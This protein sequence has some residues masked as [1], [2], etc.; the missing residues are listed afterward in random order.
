MP[1]LA[2]WYWLNYDKFPKKQVISGRWVKFHYLK[3]FVDS[4]LTASKRYAHD[5]HLSKQWTVQMVQTI[6]TTV[7][8]IKISVIWNHTLSRCSNECFTTR[9]L[10]NIPGG[11]I[12]HIVWSKDLLQAPSHKSTCHQKHLGKVKAFNLI[13]ALIALACYWKI[14]LFSRFGVDRGCST[15]TADH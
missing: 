6:Q 9:S 15:N 14:V 2:S 3:W 13:F 8:T 10:N 4:F 12:K 5:A 11:L 7:Q 1:I